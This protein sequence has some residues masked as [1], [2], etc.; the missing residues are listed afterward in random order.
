MIN[1]DICINKLNIM[2]N[3]TTLNNL[4]VQYRNIS[5]GNT[6]YLFNIHNKITKNNILYFD[7]NAYSYCPIYL[8]NTFEIYFEKYN[9]LCSFKIS[10]KNLK[11]NILASCI[12]N[13]TRKNLNDYYFPI[14]KSKDKINIKFCN[15]RKYLTTIFNNFF[16]KEENCVLQVILYEKLYFNQFLFTYYNKKYLCKIPEIKILTEKNFPQLQKYEC[17]ETIFSDNNK[18]VL[19]SGIHS[20]FITSKKMNDAIPNQFIISRLV[21]ENVKQNK[22]ILIIG[23]LKDNYEKSPFRFMI[24][25]FYPKV[26]LECKIKPNS[27]YVLSTIYCINDKDITPEI[28]I[29]NQIVHSLNNDGNEM[30]LINEETIIKMSFNENIK[31]KVENRFIIYN[32]KKISILIKYIILIVLIMM[33]KSVKKIFRI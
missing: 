28:L 23:K 1:N 14:A 12:M 7:I 18:K 22:Q 6:I 26:F 17:K 29:E 13:Q 27:K 15:Y 30:L 33:I 19:I 10:K 5:T 2:I 20:N 3:T 25:I 4:C 32:T 11:N 24:S 21:F 9:S 16:C 31:Y 8:N